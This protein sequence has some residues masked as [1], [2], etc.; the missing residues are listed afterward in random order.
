MEEV[1]RKRNYNR[2]PKAKESDSVKLEGK[3]VKISEPSISL[4]E[5]LGDVVSP[6]VKKVTDVMSVKMKVPYLEGETPEQYAKRFPKPIHEGDIGWD[7]VA[8]GIEYDEVNDR[9]IYHT[10][11]YCETDE[12]NSCFLMPRSSNSKT[13]CYLGNGIGLVDTK[14]YRGELLFAYKNRTSMNDRIVQ[15]SLV[16]YICLPWWRKIFTSIDDVFNKVYKSYIY[17]PLDYA[18]Y[19]VGDRIGQIVWLKFPTDFNVETV[20]ELSETDRGEGGFGSTGK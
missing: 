2:K 14:T 11:I 9:Y 3:S 4:S 20:D 13:D 5:S 12:G 6:I 17:N 8:T 7:V 15:T 18:P 10:G 16:E 1:K 19:E